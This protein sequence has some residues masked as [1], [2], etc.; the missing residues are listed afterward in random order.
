MQGGINTSASL[1][2]LLF[3]FPSEDAA[4]YE[5]IFLQNKNHS[6]ESPHIFLTSHFQFRSMEKHLAGTAPGS[7]FTISISSRRSPGLPKRSRNRDI[8]TSHRQLC[9]TPGLSFHGIL[10]TSHLMFCTKRVLE[11]QRRMRRGNQWL[12]LGKQQLRFLY[13]CVIL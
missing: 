1:A 2:M 13:F 12:L 6:D 7:G 3:L 8:C 10:D 4:D 5:E 11:K 9:C